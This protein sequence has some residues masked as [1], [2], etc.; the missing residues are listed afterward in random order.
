MIANV[1]GDMHAN[2]LSAESAGGDLYFTISTAA[3]RLPAGARTAQVIA[4]GLAAPHGIAVAA[5]GAVLVDDTE[6]NRVVRIDSGHVTTFAQV[7]RPDGLAVARD[8]TVYVCD[9][10]LG[11][12]VHLSAS[13]ARLGFLGGFLDTPYALAV[14]PDGGLYVAEATVSGRIVH[15]APNGKVTSLS[16]G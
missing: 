5:D 3:Y 12:I 15:V 13:G 9:G 11:R 7:D 2:L 14:A 6:H 8:G 1:T 4:E 10:A 16:S